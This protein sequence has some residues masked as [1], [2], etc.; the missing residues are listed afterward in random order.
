MRMM[1]KPIVGRPLIAA[2]GLSITLCA[3]GK[4]DPVTLVNA[5]LNEILRDAAQISGSTIVGVT[6][7]AA[8]MTPR[9]MFSGVLP[10]AWAGQAFCVSMIS[11]DGLYEAY[12]T[13]TVGPDWDG[14]AVSI[15]YPSKYPDKLT[16]LQ[17]EE[18]AI[19][20]SSGAC[21]TATDGALVPL[22]WR[23]TGAF[24]GVLR[25]FVNAFN[26]DEVYIFVGDDPTA[27]AVECR[28]P[29]S[30]T[31]VAFDFICDFEVAQDQT[32]VMIEINRVFAGQIAPPDTLAIHLADP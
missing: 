32:T 1:R 30:G 20:T 21:G 9:L 5:E 3:P 2:L 8:D 11:V 10:G 28:P 29:Q 4:A 26:A 14:G 19:L 18:L 7:V 25:M 17:A 27:P 12:N 13:Y 16:T 6:R 31:E 15:E 23:G 24:P 22:S